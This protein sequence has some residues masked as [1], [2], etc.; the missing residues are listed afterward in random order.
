MIKSIRDIF[1]VLSRPLRTG[2]F[3]FWLGGRI[4]FISAAP[5]YNEARSSLHTDTQELRDN[6]V[7]RTYRIMHDKNRLNEQVD[8]M[9]EFG[10][11]GKFKSFR[12]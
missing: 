7:E 11:V 4:W 3:V 2:S 10:G 12:A 9:E 8:I 6:R 1:E 5:F